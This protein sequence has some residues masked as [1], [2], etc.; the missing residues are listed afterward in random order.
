MKYVRFKKDDQISYG[1]IEQEQVTTIQGNIYG[2]YSLT[3]KTY[4]LSEIEL[5]VPCEPSKIVCVGLNYLDHA[6]ELGMEIPKEPVIFLKPTSALIGPGDKIEYPQM[7]QQ[8]DYEAELAIVIKQETKGISAAEAK[9]HILGYTCFNDVTARDL[10]TK[11]GQWTRAKSFDTFAPVGPAIVSDIE[12]NNL[13][14]KLLK[15]GEVK[16]N[17]NTEQMIFTVE[18]IVSFISQVMTLEAGD[19]IATGTPPGV[20]PVEVGDQIV[21]EIERVGSLKNV[22]V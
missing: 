11:D 10:Q 12:A 1:I 22:V 16:Q 5:L 3:D 9:D 7:G 21:V 19:L 6:Q 8:V 15:N 2:N 17:S 18:E 4:Q 13:E 14:I 20:G